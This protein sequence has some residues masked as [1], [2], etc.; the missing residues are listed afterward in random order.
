MKLRL[1][2][3]VVGA[4]V[5]AMA[6]SA[7]AA[8]AKG[9]GAPTDAIDVKGSISLPPPGIAF[10]DACALPN[11]DSIL[12][13]TGDIKYALRLTL[14][15][16]NRLADL[17]LQFNFGDLDARPVLSGLLGSAHYTVN[18]TLVTNQ[19]IG[20]TNG[21]GKLEPINGHFYILRAGTGNDLK[22]SVQIRGNVHSNGDLT[23]VVFDF[24]SPLRQIPLLGAMVNVHNAECGEFSLV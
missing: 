2:A 20:L 6:G 14:G 1:R 13:V 18:G 8:I 23:D 9:G 21:S 22:L 16:G 12:F 7:N 3:I 10:I 19:K 5:L 11:L 4:L 24:G 15:R 17:R